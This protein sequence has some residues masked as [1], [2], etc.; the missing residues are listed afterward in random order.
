MAARTAGRTWLA[1]ALDGGFG[2]YAA[3]W[4]AHYKRYERVPSDGQHG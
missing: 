3:F 1:A 4:H 2:S